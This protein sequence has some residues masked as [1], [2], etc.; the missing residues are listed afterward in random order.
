MGDQ[1]YYSIKDL[2][3][4]LSA[5]VLSS[6]DI[7]IK[8]SNGYNF[9]KWRRLLLMYIKDTCPT[10]F[11]FVETGKIDSILEGYSIS[12]REEREIINIMDSA[13]KRIII[14]ITENMALI[15]VQDYLLNEYTDHSGRGLLNHLT[16]CFGQHKVKYDISNLKQYRTTT[17]LKDKIN[18][19]NEI[20]NIGFS[21]TDIDTEILSILTVEQKKLFLQERHKRQRY[22]AS[23]VFMNSIPR[24]SDKIIEKFGDEDM[25]TIEQ[26]CEEFLSSRLEGES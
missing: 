4:N 21:L 22:L 6:A 18:Y 25:I 10:W 7:P 23:L 26:I 19:A 14:A 17:S 1:M 20:A 9:C 5:E 3:Q 16:E 15:T 12:D 13:L 8:L 2:R 24:Y 11:E